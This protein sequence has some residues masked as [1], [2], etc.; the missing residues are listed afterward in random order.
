MDTP[1][2]SIKVFEQIAVQ[3]EK[4]ILDGELCTGIACPSNV[5]WLNSFRSVVPQYVKR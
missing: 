2:Q 4:R 3:I 5:S 1:I